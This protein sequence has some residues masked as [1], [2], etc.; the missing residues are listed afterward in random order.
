M[1]NAKEGKKML[2]PLEMPAGLKDAIE[3]AAKKQRLSAAEW[4]RRA[5]ATSAGYRLR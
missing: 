2:A 5:L 3:K 1:E 4:A